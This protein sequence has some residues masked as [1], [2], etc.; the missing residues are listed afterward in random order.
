MH[1]ED[2]RLTLIARGHHAPPRNWNHAASAPERLIFLNSFAVLSYLLSNGSEAARHD[3]RRIIIDHAG[4][5]IEFLELLSSLPHEI[6]A[7][8][9]LISESAA[10]LSAI[11]RGGDRV[12]YRLSP[13]DVDFYLDAHGMRNEEEDRNPRLAAVTEKRPA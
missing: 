8:V 9:L 3:V 13:A 2:R 12:M 11:G 6:T 10:F 4:G 7:D 1:A 5:A